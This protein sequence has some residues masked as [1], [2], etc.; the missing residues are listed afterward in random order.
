[1]GQL[2]LDS[3]L[4]MV[5]RVAV[6]FLALAA[7]C[8]CVLLGAGTG[9]GSCAAAPFR[10]LSV[11]WPGGCPA[12]AP[13][14]SE[15]GYCQTE[16]NWVLGKFRDCNGKS[17]GTPLA[18]DVIAAETAAAAQGDAAAQAILTAAGVATA[19]G[20][21]TAGAGAVRISVRAAGLGAG[22]PVGVGAA[23]LSAGAAGF[24]TGATGF[25]ARAAGVY[26]GFG[27]GAAGYTRG[28]YPAFS[29][30]FGYPASVPG[31]Q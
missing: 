5:F 16:E 11:Y 23:G 2:Y 22:A 25:G 20:G 12:S 27:A 24:A 7:S 13:C 15:Y 9:D 19:T 14:C 29:A 26:G 28:A 10:S 6:F 8:H 18:A 21:Y 3:T 1:M 4:K 31:V 30:G 17:N